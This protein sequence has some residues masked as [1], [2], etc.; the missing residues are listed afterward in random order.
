MPRIP[1][2][3]ACAIALATVTPVALAQQHHHASA[4]ATSDAAPAPAQRYATDATLRQQMRAIRSEVDALAD[5]AHAGAARQ[6][7]AQAGERITGHVN[8]IIAE[9]K[10]PPDAD[11]ALHAILGPILQDASVLKSSPHDA[12]AI[13]G[14]QHALGQ[15]AQQFDDPTFAGRRR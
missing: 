14:L 7:P 15:Y 2:V 9:C 1:F 8:I 4:S 3:L 12:T 11:E 5:N 13:A 10:L 6:P